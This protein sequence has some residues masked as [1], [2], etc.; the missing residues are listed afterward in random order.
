MSEFGAFTRLDRWAGSA[1]PLTLLT[2]DGK[3]PTQQDGAFAY[4]KGSA[5]SLVP[6]ALA[7]PLAPGVE[8]LAV[9]AIT[10]SA[11]IACRGEAP[12]TWRSWREL[13]LGA[14]ELAEGVVGPSAPSSA[15]EAEAVVR[16]I[17]LL[18]FHKSHA[19]YGVDGTPTTSAG[20]GRHRATTG[21]R[22]IYPRTDPVA[23]CLVESA[24]GQRT[25]LG[26]QATFPP[27]VFSCVAGF[28][29]LA[30][31]A[32]AAAIREVLEETGVRCAPAA[33]VA[34]QPWPI[35]RGGGSELMLG[36]VARVT[37]A[38]AET[39]NVGSG[40][41]EG[42]GELSEA[43]WFTRAEVAAMMAR[44]HEEGLTLPPRLAIARCL[45]ERWAA[46]ALRPLVAEAAVVPAT[47]A[48]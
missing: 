11:L 9:D 28:V 45:I 27:G 38:D 22:I 12:P 15:V 43:R 47:P 40:E 8:A 18:A 5:G 10:A 16:A 37:D 23:I 24:D 2:V 25:L 1:E 42:S 36:C 32:E 13:L 35:G 31:S 6:G 33:L 34:S 26:R 48:L 44:S 3:A 4:V 41:R 30:E 39:I 20:G 17:A 21:G 29:E 46:G 19:F 14:P 7:V